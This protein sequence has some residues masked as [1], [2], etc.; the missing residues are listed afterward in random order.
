MLNAPTLTYGPYSGWAAV[1]FATAADGT[2]CVLVALNW[3][4]GVHLGK[5]TLMVPRLYWRDLSGLY[6]GWTPIAIGA[7]ADGQTRLLWVNGGQASLWLLDAAGQPTRHRLHLWT[8]CGAKRRAS[9]I[10]RSPPSAVLNRDGASRWHRPTGI[11]R[12]VE[13]Q[14]CGGCHA[15]QRASQQRRSRLESATPDASGQGV[16]LTLPASLH[17]GDQVSIEWHDLSDAQ[18]KALTGQAGPVVAR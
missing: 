12:R 13:C 5:W 17:K 15:L 11:Q 4:P 18:G 16:T 9:A 8:L 10:R 6:S 2:A 14:N 3:R 1:D 7:G